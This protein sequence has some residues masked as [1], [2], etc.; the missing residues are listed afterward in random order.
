MSTLTQDS[1]E[2]SPHASVDFL[3]ETTVFTKQ[4]ES[5]QRLRFFLAETE[6]F[7]PSCRLPSKRISS[8]P[9]YD[10]FDTSPNINYIQ[11]LFYSKS[12]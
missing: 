2:K 10:R 6:G 4:K 11:M 1:Q 8:A 7:E 3:A 5:Q 12:F 9:R